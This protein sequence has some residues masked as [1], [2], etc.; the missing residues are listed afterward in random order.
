MLLL[1]FFQ[2]LSAVWNGKTLRGE[3]REFTIHG[4]SKPNEEAPRLKTLSVNNGP[5]LNCIPH[6][7]VVKPYNAIAETRGNQPVSWP[8]KVLGLYIL[9]ADDDEEGFE[10]DSDSWEPELYD[11]QQTASNVLFFTFIHPDT[12]EVPPAFQKL[13]DSRGSGKRGSVPANTVILFAIG[14]YSYSIKPNPWHWLTSR[15][16]AEEMAEKVAEWPE[17][18]GCDGI[19]LDL[20]EGAGGRREAGPNMIHFIRRLRQLKPHM[21]ISQPTYGYPQVRAE[22]DV[23]NASW[24]TKGKHLGVA[25]AIGL[26]VYEGTQALNYV[27]NYANG[28]SQWEGFPIKVNAPKNAILLGNLF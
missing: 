26:M 7:E 5:T 6:Y 22:I 14:G 8:K 2:I 3:I 1:I 16:A 24:D 10:S 20:E 9:L 28:T 18:Y 4:K 21:I 17:K 27:K 25:D 19:D 13:A 23:I 15:Q 11:W 12:M